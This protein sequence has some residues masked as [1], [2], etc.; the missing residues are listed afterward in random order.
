M[1]PRSIFEKSRLTM[2]AATALAL[3]LVSAAVAA[4]RSEAYI[5]PLFP[6]KERDL[7]NGPPPGMT[8]AS[9]WAAHGSAKLTKQDDGKVKI[10]F[11]LGGL[12]PNGVYTLWNVLETEPFKDEPLGEFG[13]GKHSVVAD[14]GGNAHKIVVI[15]KWPGKDFLLDYHS[16]GSLS[17]AKAVYPGALWGKFPAEPAR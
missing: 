13:S 9:F 15:G 17:Q 2:S 6:Q 8:A 1:P 14:G 4:E 7:K 11:D 10:E 16:D 12:I 5:V 3:L